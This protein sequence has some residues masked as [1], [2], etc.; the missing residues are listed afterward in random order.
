VLP[1]TK[2]LFHD[3]PY[4]DGPMIIPDADEDTHF[5]PAVD[6]ILCVLKMLMD[7]IVLILNCVCYAGCNRIHCR[8]RSAANS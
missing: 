7:V 5:L 1:P 8:R 6:S 2:T 3:K 4:A